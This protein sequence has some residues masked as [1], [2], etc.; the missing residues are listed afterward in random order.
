ML[1]D[2][3]KN[4]YKKNLRLFENIEWNWI[5]RTFSIIIKGSDVAKVNF[6]P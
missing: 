5:Y 3:H 4:L 6:L 2:Q 1:N